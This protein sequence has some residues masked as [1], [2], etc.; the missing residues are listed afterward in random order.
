MKMRKN[1][2]VLICAG[3][4]FSV[5]FDGFDKHNFMLRNP[6]HIISPLYQA[7]MLNGFDG[8]V[9][10]EG[11]DNDTFQGC[12]WDTVQIDWDTARVYEKKRLDLRRES[13][14]E[15]SY[16]ESGVE[17]KINS[18]LWISDMKFFLWGQLGIWLPLTFQ[19]LRKWTYPIFNPSFSNGTSSFRD[20]EQAIRGVIL[21]S[22]SIKRKLEPQIMVCEC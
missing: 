14:W 15:I 20:W 16:E 2:F 17:T 7:V 11:A 8:C 22:F 4:G 12:F 13:M 10:F 18:K 6:K 3:R 5:L 21:L 19:D 1:P 9:E